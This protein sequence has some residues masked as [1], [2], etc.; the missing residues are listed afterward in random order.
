[1][2][3]FI[4]LSKI[5]ES[6]H[7]YIVYKVNTFLVINVDNHNDTVPTIFNIPNP[8]KRL[9]T[10]R[11]SKYKLCNT[12]PITVEDNVF[13]QIPDTISVNA[14]T[15]KDIDNSNVESCINCHKYV[16]EIA[17]LKKQIAL[18]Q[19]LTDQQINVFSN[20]TH[21]QQWDNETIMKS[22]KIRFAV[23]V[24]G[25]QYLRQMNF[26]LS[27]YSTITR[28]LQ[29]LTLEF[30]LFESM[31]EPLAF[32]VQQL[33]KED[34]FCVLSF[35]EMEISCE[36]SYDKNRSKRYGKITLRNTDKLGN[37]LLLVLLRSVKNNWKQ[38]IGA[39]I[40]DRS[41]APELIKQFIY[42]CIDFCKTA[43]LNVVSLS[44]DMG[45][46]NKSLW[47][48]LGNY[49]TYD[50]NNVFIMPDVCH[51][52]KNL[53]TEEAEGLPT[54]YVHCKFVADSWN[55]EQRRNSD[56]DKELCLL[57]HLKRE[58][59][60]SNNFQKINVGSAVRFFSLKTIATVETA[61]NCKLLPKDALTTAHF[62]RLIY[63]WFS[64][65]ANKL[66]KTSIT[67][68]K[69]KKYDY[70]QKLI[71]LVQQIEFGL[72]IW[73]PLNV[74]ENLF[75][76][77]RRKAGQTP[78]AIQS[79]KMILMLQYISDV[80]HSSY[81]DDSDEFLLNHFKK[82][83]ENFNTTSIDILH[84][85]YNVKSLEILDYVENISG[86]LKILPEYDMNIVFHLAGSVT[87]AILKVS[88]NEFGLFMCNTS[89]TE[90][91]PEKY[92]F[93]TKSLNKGGLKEPCIKYS[94][95]QLVI[96]LFVKNEK[97]YTEQQQKRKK[98]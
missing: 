50:D 89:E 40:T 18:K 90:N 31:L 71:G 78:N 62:I 29:G 88:C 97:R 2:I 79:L 43:D 20:K 65:T 12:R 28:Q 13:C 6:I 52:N 15:S 91:L 30:G 73:K 9:M 49:F 92:M 27:C 69:E 3:L 44:S 11:K 33:E 81:M 93:Y 34:R 63:E 64:L 37:K 21:V 68:K 41:P 26:P 22:L 57:H 54:E 48:E 80:K 7:Q 47:K 94:L 77:M 10:T 39:H 60:Y 35:D 23:G 51:L 98:N 56:R 1:M 32:K 96:Y 84:P 85:T 24:H 42:D 66:R 16:N 8:L 83:L 19:F 46:E 53:K 61:V 74:V 45:N 59:I 86:A 14:D 82:V 87:N 76:Q 55:I 17:E 72:N 25:F 5:N 67:K 70:L 95:M 36:E 38:V 58:V 75:S 4:F